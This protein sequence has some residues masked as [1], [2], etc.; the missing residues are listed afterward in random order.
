YKVLQSLYIYN[1]LILSPRRQQGTGACLR[2]EDFPADY[3]TIGRNGTYGKKTHR[4][5]GD[6]EGDF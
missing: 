5:A 3:G 4:A 6:A 2:K 1:I